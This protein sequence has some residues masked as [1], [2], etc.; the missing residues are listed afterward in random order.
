MRAV[1][2]LCKS[3]KPSVLFLA[4]IKL[5]YQIRFSSIVQSLHFDHFFFVPSCGSSCG[6]A[7]MWINSV[8]ISVISSSTQLISIMILNDPPTNPWQ[9]TGVYG[10]TNPLLKPDFW[11]DLRQIASTFFGPMCFAGDFN[12]ILDQKEKIGGRTFSCGSVCRFRSLVDDLRLIDLEFSGNTFTWTNRRAG[13]ANIQERPDRGL[14]VLSGVSCFLLPIFSTFLLTS[15]IINQF[16]LLPTLNAL[17]APN[18]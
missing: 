13:R 12:A 10:P 3:Q 1:R 17:V 18:L 2:D 5:F 11:V 8:D 6:I 15:L 16:F 7:F 9:L 14:V 4:E